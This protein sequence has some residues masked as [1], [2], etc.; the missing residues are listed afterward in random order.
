[1]G[2]GK[3]LLWLR[4]ILS[5]VLVI[6]L[7]IV[8][9]LVS[10]T[11]FEP[12]VVEV[13]A[14]N[15]AVSSTDPGCYYLKKASPDIAFSLKNESSSCD[16]ELTD[17]DDDDVEVIVDEDSDTTVIVNPPE[18]G[19]EKGA[20]YTLVL[21]ENTYFTD[22]DL[23]KA[24]KLIFTI[25]RDEIEHYEFKEGVVETDKTLRLDS[26]GNLIIP[27]GEDY[28]TGDIAF[29][30]DENGEYVIY[31]IVEV[32]GDTAT[33]ETPAF[34]EIFED[35]QIYGDYRWDVSTLTANPNL[36]QEVINNVVSSEFYSDLMYAAYEGDEEKIAMYA[37]RPIDAESSVVQTAA[38]DSV[39]MQQLA[40]ASVELGDFEFSYDIDEGENTVTFDITI[41]IQAGEG[42]VFGIEELESHS[43][44][45]NLSAT[46]GCDT[47][48][49]IDNIKNWDLSYTM[50]AD[51]SWSID[52]NMV[53]GE[54]SAD[55]DVDDLF[56][57]SGI[58]AD[59]H[60]IVKKL[61]D[62]LQQFSKD[63]GDINMDLF[64]WK[65][66]IPAVPG[67]FFE[68]EVEIAIGFEMSADVTVGN[69]YSTKYT[70]GIVLRKGKFDAYSREYA[71][72][73][74]PTLS[75]R[76]MMGA[77]LGVQLEMQL[78]FIDD[79]VAYIGITPQVGGYIDI[80]AL[81]PILGA[82]EISG[83]KGSY[84]YVETGF[85]MQVSLDAYVNLFWSDD[86][87]FGPMVFE[88][89]WPVPADGWG[90]SQIALGVEASE[91]AVAADE[92]GLA[93]VPDFVFEY[94]DAVSG[95][96]KT[97]V[98]S[99][100]KFTLYDH[101]GTRVVP[102]GGKIDVSGFSEDENIIIRAVYVHD[103]DKEYEATFSV[104]KSSSAIEGQVSAFNRGDHTPISGATVSVYSADSPGSEIFS[105]TTGSDGL[106]HF[107]VAP[108][109]YKLK[110]SARGYKTLVTTQTVGVDEIK[111]TE[112]LLM[113]DESQDGF[114]IAK[115]KISDALN[116]NGISGVMI[117]LREEWNNTSGGYVEGF[118]AYSD[119][120][121]EYY[122]ENLPVGYYTL[123]A[124]ADGYGMTHC[125]ILVL[126][127]EDLVRFDFA[128]TPHLEEGTVRIILNWG[129]SPN[130]LDSHLLGRTPSGD[131][132]R[133]Y[134]SSKQYYYGD[135]EMANLDYDDTNSYGPETIT[136]LEDINGTYTYAV[137]DYSNRSSTSS[138]AMSYSGARVRVMIGG[139]D[140]VEEFYI[141]TNRTG[142]YWTV[143]TIDSDLN[144]T[145]VNT[146]SNTDPAE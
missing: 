130:D 97:K 84:V 128:M 62:K 22:T 85:Y 137:H 99:I 102:M 47:H 38:G 6:V 74:A 134:Y 119:S 96:R 58:S 48:L 60:K 143:F 72:E 113:L 140:T 108:G 71:S 2:K 19:Y 54:L 104:S 11:V 27:D 43:I 4:R 107:N 20:T 83:E 146:V 127:E 95:V 114:G 139:R 68:A 31:K 80:Y 135:T 131:S 112:H 59:H 138:T 92:D 55:P 132:F 109:T 33:V 12:G 121:G 52:L 94:Y 42:G 35:L 115:G 3:G 7:F 34:D 75:V 30:Q 124:T 78:C 89:K 26:Y 86:L 40:G 100:D 133:V 39:Q 70:A 105:R 82:S 36:E 29:G 21:S 91:R 15:I 66:P 44:K 93:S 51:Y 120:Y 8:S 49:Y 136:I 117:K 13:Y 64:E 41:P 16:F 46:L 125:N 101:N 110:I 106:F 79:D 1:M 65:I 123:E 28:E 69:S 24:R 98:L 37:A 17:E 81:A 111:Y 145:P 18:G 50:T 144:V 67:V 10:V 87:R 5:V 45:L 61:S 90:T 122:I 73:S 116:G 56:K 126:E 129:E 9:Y 57:K 118:T 76:G 23:A 103:N 32:Y 77:K 14:E 142:I 53:S 25:D 88:K 63:A 141:P